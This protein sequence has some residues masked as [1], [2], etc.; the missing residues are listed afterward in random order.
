MSGLFFLHHFP[1]L[2]QEDVFSAQSGQEQ[3]GTT[4]GTITMQYQDADGRTYTLQQE[5]RT[6]IK[7]PRLMPSETKTPEEG[8]PWWISASAV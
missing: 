2:F 7:K 6:E 1:G 5:F 3:H 4:D 8:S